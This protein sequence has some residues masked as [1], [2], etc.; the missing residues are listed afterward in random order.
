MAK[1]RLI[2]LAGIPGTGKT[3][4]GNYLRDRHNF[5][6]LDAENFLK[7]GSTPNPADLLIKS[8]KNIVVTWGF[9]PHVDIGRDGIRILRQLGFTPVWF[10][11]NRDVALTNYN[12]RGTDP[13]TDFRLQLGNIDR[14]GIAKEFSPAI[15][16]PFTT[17][18]DFKDPELLAQEV[19]R[20]TE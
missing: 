10:E 20:A 2:F 6:H 5:D 8:D 14:T 1:R 13:E 7:T 4:F 17:S 15:I 12:K 3:S 19:F 18:G 11:G 9:R 16:D